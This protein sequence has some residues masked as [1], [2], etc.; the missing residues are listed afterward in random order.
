MKRERENVCVWGFVCNM[1]HRPKLVVPLYRACLLHK[2]TCS[3]I[4]LAPSSQD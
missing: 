3:H 1:T 2:S 4:Q